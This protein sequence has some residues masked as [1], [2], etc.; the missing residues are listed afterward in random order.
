MCASNTREHKE[1]KED[2]KRAEDK[3]DN[4]VKP[5]L[6]YWVL[7]G[8]FVC[9]MILGGMVMRLQ[10]DLDLHMDRARAAFHQIT[11]EEY[12]PPESLR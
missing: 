7:G 2:I 11:G 9:L 5:Q 8:V 10:D 1:I 12:V 4:R 3:M 6:F